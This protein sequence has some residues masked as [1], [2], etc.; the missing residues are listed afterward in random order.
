M[1]CLVL[2]YVICIVN[3]MKARIHPPLYQLS[4]Q[5]WC[6]GMGDIFLA[7]FEPFSAS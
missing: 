1:F 3:N 6:N 5:W 4:R 2:I 7:D